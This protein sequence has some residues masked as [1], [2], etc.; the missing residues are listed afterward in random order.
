MSNLFLS[1]PD[2]GRGGPLDEATDLRGSLRLIKQTL[3]NGWPIPAERLERI[4]EIAQNVMDDDNANPRARMQALDLIVRLQDQNIKI[5]DMMR[6]RLA[7]L[8]G[9]KQTINVNA[10][11]QPA[12]T[13]RIE[14]L[15]ALIA[16]LAQPR[17]EDT[18][19]V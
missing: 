13:G 17:G 15:R 5:F 11:Q 4:I 12:D 9:S 16:R 8:E 19:D 2:Y 18:A 1:A 7:D 14:A 6:K 10:G 3:G